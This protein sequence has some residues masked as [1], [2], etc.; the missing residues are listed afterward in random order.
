MQSLSKEEQHKAL[1]DLKD[2]EKALKNDRFKRYFNAILTIVIAITAFKVLIGTI[3][4]KALF[5]H[6]AFSLE[7][8]NIPVGII[9]KQELSKDFIPFFARYYNTYENKFFPGDNFK[10]IYE[11]EKNNSYLIKINTYECFYQIRGNKTNCENSDTKQIEVLNVKYQLKILQNNEVL[12]DGDFIEDITPYIKEGKYD[13][14]LTH[15]S[16]DITTTLK[17]TIVI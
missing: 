16:N 5:Y 7:I 3:N 8:N 17:T 9:S 13:I 6:N 14:I 12:Y 4:V 15:K 2:S 1:K 10:D 11:I